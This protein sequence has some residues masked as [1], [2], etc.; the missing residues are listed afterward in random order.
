[1]KTRT[2]YYNSIKQVGNFAEAL[3]LYADAVRDFP[4]MENHNRL[5]GF[6]QE[7]QLIF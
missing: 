2:Y 4:E 7:K 3:M 6:I 5:I 1:M